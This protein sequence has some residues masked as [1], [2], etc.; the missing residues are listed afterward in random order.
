[1]GIDA[2][3]L[4][5]VKGKPTSNQLKSWGWQLS[6]ALGSEHFF[7]DKKE[8]HGVISYSNTRYREEGDPEPG[9]IYHQDGDDIEASPG[10]TLLTVHVWSRYYGVGYE[11]GDLITLCAIA[12]WCEVNIPA[13]E[14]WYGG[15]S[16]GILAKHWPD[17]ARR[18]LRN[19]LYSA[20][21]QDYHRAWHLGEG[22]PVRPEPCVLCVG[23]GDFNECGWSGRGNAPWL[24]VHCPGC[25]EYFET[26]D[27]GK[28]WSVVE[29]KAA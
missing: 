2:R 6:A 27:Q 12:E 25:G 28:T 16:S 19:H 9:T 23:A 10:E 26:H 22:R 4:L 17:S 29:K 7:F 18:A 13:C 14:V 5:R 21:G 15:D 3:I 11:R 20:N 24:K 8:G 1:L